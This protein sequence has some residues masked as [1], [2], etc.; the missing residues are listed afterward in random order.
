[1][2]LGGQIEEE[3]IDEADKRKV[4][5]VAQWISLFCYFCNA[6]PI[7]LFYTAGCE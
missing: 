7:L 2:F 1:M 3:Q 6:F 5:N 4:C